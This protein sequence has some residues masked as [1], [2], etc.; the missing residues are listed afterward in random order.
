VKCE[1]AS[2]HFWFCAETFGLPK[3]P[4][5]TGKTLS[6][7]ISATNRILVAKIIKRNEIRQ[8]KLQVKYIDI[9]IRTDTYK[10]RYPSF[11][12]SYVA[13]TSSFSQIVAYILIA[14]PDSY[15]IFR[16]VVIHSTSGVFT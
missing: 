12:R 7:P 1:F 8:M 10:K 2:F 14:T 9:R 11:P 3:K 15:F 16:R 5:F 13:E 4:E 6:L